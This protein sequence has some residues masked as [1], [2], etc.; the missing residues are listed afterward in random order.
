MLV[1]WQNLLPG[2]PSS[3]FQQPG[4]SFRN[5]SDHHQVIHLQTPPSA[6]QGTLDLVSAPCAFLFM[7]PF[8]CLYCSVPII[9][10][11]FLLPK[12][13]TFV[14]TPGPLHDLYHCS[15]VCTAIFLSFR[16]QLERH[17]HKQSPFLESILPCQYRSFASP[18]LNFFITLITFQMFSLI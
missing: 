13:M 3:H 14:P 17:F 2:C 16:F 5:K 12:P 1:D 8:L 15:Q 4:L 7:Y 10:A 6:L 18:R 9:L 11:S